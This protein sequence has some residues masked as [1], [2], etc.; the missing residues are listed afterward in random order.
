MSSDLIDRRINSLAPIRK[1]LRELH[2]KGQ[3]FGREGKGG[4]K[5]RVFTA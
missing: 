4:G 1:G 5:M 2:V 3:I